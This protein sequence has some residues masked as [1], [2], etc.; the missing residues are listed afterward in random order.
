MTLDFRCDLAVWK[1]AN[2]GILNTLENI[3]LFVEICIYIV[4]MH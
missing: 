1:Q 3:F 2:W 4:Q